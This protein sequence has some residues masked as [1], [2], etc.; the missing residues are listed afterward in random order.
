MLPGHG[1]SIA[2]ISG[3]MSGKQLVFIGI[4]AYSGYALT[5]HTPPAPAN[6]SEAEVAAATHAGIGARFNYGIGNVGVHLMG[7]T[8][9][10]MVNETQQSLN[11]MHTAIR[12]AKGP[13]GMR[14]Q[15]YSKKIVQMDSVALSELSYGKPIKA[16]KTAM[17]AKS[18][19]NSVRQNLQRNI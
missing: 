4:L 9:R 1:P 13:D 11:D 3:T 12:N 8:V 2:L 6:A 15:Q 16:A 5:R 10:G 17:E 7:G 14:A 19:L 18:L